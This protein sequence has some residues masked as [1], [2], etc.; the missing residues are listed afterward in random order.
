MTS[1]EL[2]G[3]FKKNTKTDWIIDES[4]K[5][6]KEILNKDYLPLQCKNCG[7]KKNIP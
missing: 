3:I 2:K 6:P 4:I 5:L 1:T 7:H